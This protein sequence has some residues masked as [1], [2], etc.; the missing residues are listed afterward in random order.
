MNVGCTSYKM[1]RT[2]SAVVTWNHKTANRLCEIPRPSLSEITMA[3]LN[4]SVGTYTAVPLTTAA[5]AH[6]S[7]SGFIFF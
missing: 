2:K 7:S 1:T 4:P 3:N 5:F 6:G